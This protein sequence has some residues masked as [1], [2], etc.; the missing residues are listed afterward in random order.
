MVSL[1]GAKL[2]KKITAMMERDQDNPE[3]LRDAGIAYAVEQILVLLSQGIDGIHL[4]TTNNV[5]VTQ[6]IS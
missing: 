2:P 6:K 5:Y 4:Y 1:C 3:S